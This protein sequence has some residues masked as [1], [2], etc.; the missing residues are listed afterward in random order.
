MTTRMA[1]A[2]QGRRG[3]WPGSRGL[4]PGSQWALA[5]VTVGSGRGRRG[6]W[7]GAGRRCPRQGCSVLLCVCPEQVAWPAQPSTLGTPGPH[8]PDHEGE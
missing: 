3:L 2:G 1:S 8:V 7:L 5:A 6:L 4:W